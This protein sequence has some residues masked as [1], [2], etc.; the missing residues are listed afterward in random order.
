MKAENKTASTQSD[1]E[2]AVVI[3]AYNEEDT[4]AACIQAL[5]NGIRKPARIIVADGCSE[6]ATAEVARSEGAV[7]VHNSK[8]TAAA[9]RNIGAQH[10]ETSIIAF[11]DAD[12]LPS[13][14]WLDAIARR[15]ETGCVDG[16]AGKIIPRI[17]RNRYEAYWN[18]LAWEVIMHFGD[19]PAPIAARDLSH[20]VIT[21]SCAWRSDVLDQLNGFDE[22]F[23]NNAEDVDLTWRALDA[24]FVLA[25]EPN[26]VVEA[27]GPLTA[28]DMRRKA[29][30]NGVSSSKLQKRYGGIVSY[31]PSMYKML[32][33]NL[34][35]KSRC[36]EPDLERQELIWHLLGKYFGSVRYGVVNV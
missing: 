25:Y 16:L 10:A 8:H 7:V 3:P 23:G 31:D 32:V 36:A 22:W 15:F 17:P 27:N 21:A 35:H 30:R 24:G 4:I 13:S 18:N 1:A 34:M 26:A 11:T 29:F 33:A 5:W 20:S 12:C 9:G 6:D 14:G 28:H 19:K 2:I